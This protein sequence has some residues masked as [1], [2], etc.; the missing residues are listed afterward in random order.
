MVRN[1]QH[2]INGYQHCKSEEK[3][4]QDRKRRVSLF[5]FIYGKAGTS[6]RDQLG[7]ERFPKYFQTEWGHFPSSVVM[8]IINFKTPNIT[9]GPWTELSNWLPFL[10]LPA[11]PLLFA[12]DREILA[13]AKKEGRKEGGREGVFA[14]GG[15]EKAQR[16]CN[17]FQGN[18]SRL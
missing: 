6:R 14:Q 17:T 4:N 2:Q 18:P 7:I 8:K 13:E 9:A 15:A 16:I 5:S 1:W 10:F 3:R 12:P 11:P